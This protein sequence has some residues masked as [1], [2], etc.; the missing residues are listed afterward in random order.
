M[1]QTT[2][3]GR[4][5]DCKIPAAEI[6]ATLSLG[7]DDNGNLQFT[8]PWGSSNIKLGVTN[9]LQK[10][11]D[12]DQSTAFGDGD[13]P[14]F[15]GTLGKFK[16]YP[17]L[18]AIE[19]TMMF[20]VI[21]AGIGDPI[22]TTASEYSIL[23]LTLSPTVIGTSMSVA[24]GTISV[25]SD[26]QWLELSG[27]LQVSSEEET[28]FTY[29]WVYDDGSLIGSAETTHVDAGEAT[30]VVLPTQTWETNGGT[31]LTLRV[32]SVEAG[33]TV[34][35]ATLNARQIGPMQT[36]AGWSSI[37]GDIESLLAAI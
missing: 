14:V 13:G 35:N 6:D 3:D 7:L 5:Q 22:T 34:Q 28:D 15:D 9:E 8:S 33:V 1:D 26:I 16:P 19:G 4:Y 12:V 24:D 27:S 32:L 2:I 36:A 11:S 23:E 30:V 10:L 25:A 21:A 17:L 29:Q 31:G 20:S 37:L 18:T